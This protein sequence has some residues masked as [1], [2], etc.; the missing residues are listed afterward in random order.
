MTISEASQ[1]AKQYYDSDDADGF[2][3]R[4]WGGE[5]IHIGMYE[6]DTEPIFEASR[7]TVETMASLL[8]E[9]SN[10]HR[11]LDVGAGYGGAARIL[12]QRF[13]C[14]VTCLNLS[15]VQNERNRALNEY[16]GLA[17]LIDV[18]DG[19]FEKMPFEDGE[20]DVIWSEDAILHAGEHRADVLAECVRVL[21]PGGHFVFTDPMMADDCPAGVLQP[22]YDRIHLDSLGSIGFYRDAF[23]RLGM[24]EIGVHDHSECLPQHY[25]RVKQELQSRYRQLSEEL[26]T[27]YLDRMI[28]G[29]QHWVDAGRAGHLAWGVLHF[30]KPE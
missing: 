1:T 25:A 2:Y 16:A 17:D 27:E 9:L 26:S 8:P 14:R 20:Y 28:V 29:L 3:S 21:K 7:R 19:S 18:V 30:Q 23:A 11:V 12:A 6:S 5:D 10:T 24:R 13:G 15:T 4:I 22:I